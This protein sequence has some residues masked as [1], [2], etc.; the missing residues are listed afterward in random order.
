MSLS[1]PNGSIVAI[2]AAYATALNVTAASNA[3]QCVLT[4]TN[5]YAVGDFV[6]VTS[7]WSGLNNKV[8]RVGAVSGTTVTLEGFDTTATAR[9]PALGGI[10]T[11]RKITSYTQLAQ[12][13][14]S[15][16][17]GGEQNYATVQ[18]LE[19]DG[20]TEIPTFKTP[21][22]ITFGVGDD[23]TLPGYILAKAANDDGAQRAVKVSLKSGG[24]LSYNAFVS[25]GDTPSLTV[26]EVMQI[27]CTLA[28]RTSPVR[29]AT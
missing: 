20:Q 5:T 6:E 18:F 10:G 3:S 22:R 17:S 1:L 9:F 23:V 26:N 12:I 7:G 16:S 21:T 19:S 15:E 4:V 28:L 11:V 14:S 27:P 25:I 29:Y 13:L 24:V 8:L 2:A